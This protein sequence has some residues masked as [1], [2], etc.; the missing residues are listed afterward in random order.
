[1]ERKKKIDVTVNTTTQVD[2]ENSDNSDTFAV[3]NTK[4]RGVFLNLRSFAAIIT[5]CILPREYTG[6]REWVAWVEN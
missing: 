6:W 1:M 2:N 4:Q 3:H 5:T